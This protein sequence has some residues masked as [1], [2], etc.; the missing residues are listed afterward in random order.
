MGLNT[1]A[2][3]WFSFGVSSFSWAVHYMFAL[4]IPK[5]KAK[6]ENV[7][8]NSLLNIKMSERFFNVIPNLLLFNRKDRHNDTISHQRYCQLPCPSTP[9]TPYSNSLS[10]LQTYCFILR[11][12]HYSHYGSS[13]CFLSSVWSVV[14]LLVCAPSPFVCFPDSLVFEH[15]CSPLWP[16]PFA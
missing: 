11:S 5:R 13:L 7:A 1:Q 9:W 2:S 10:G 15:F 8:M 3:L 4:M 6:L 16:C 12:D 14:L